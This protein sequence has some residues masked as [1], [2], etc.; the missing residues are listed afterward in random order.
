[1]INGP[2]TQPVP[3]TTDS[4]VAAEPEPPIAPLG[5]QVFRGSW[6]SL[7]SQATMLGL[8]LVSTVVLARLLTPRAYGVVAMVTV[9]TG[10]IG[11][12]KT[13]GLGTATI[14][15]PQLTHAQ[16]NGVFWINVGFG[17]L[18]MLVTI[19]I[20]PAMAWF[21]GEPQV[22]ALTLALAVTFVF[23]G[24]GVQHAALLRRHFRFG[25][26]A[27]IDVSSAVFGAATTIVF[28][29]GGAGPWSLVAGLIAIELC[30][31]VLL[32]F[33][34][35]WRPTRPRID[36]KIS[37]MV[38]LG[39]DLT[40]FNVLVYW[41]RNL[42]NFLIGRYWGSTQLGLYSRAYQLLLLPLQQVTT[43][44]STVAI[45]ALSRLSGE[46]VRY[47]Q[48]Y[49][50]LLEKVAIA[51]M[52]MT[53][54]LFV[55]GHRLIAV[56]LGATW[57]DVVPIFRP[58]AIAGMVQPVSATLIWLLV[59]QGR[60][61][62]LRR[63]SFTGPAFTCAAI[64]AGLPGGPV[65]VATM[66]AAVDILVRTPLLVWLVSRRG[67]VGAGSIAKALRPGVCAATAV[68]IACTAMSRVMPFEGIE[69][70]AISSLTALVAA[71]GMLFALPSGRQAFADIVDLLTD[72]RVVRARS[73]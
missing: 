72:A 59:S 61:Q 46:D 34:V 69:G 42:D 23:G 17:C 57:M 29:L 3:V 10:F 56:L 24:S 13:L 52:P 41:A 71:G 54:F 37:E 25:T 9:V 38:G 19:A 67:P 63:W 49:V 6:I 11:L 21:Y 12:F 33:A 1:M 20:A 35:E 30:N 14:Q 32:W 55:E 51:C 39:R 16:L 62:D 45:S 48:A 47:Q 66:Y 27:A 18:A 70:L 36:A 28:A 73:T 44:L 64:V 50:R 31:V 26:A 60:R 4:P 43:P 5:G 53:T 8:R 65:G 68:F 40:L 15:A 2:V 7:V 22:T 58:L